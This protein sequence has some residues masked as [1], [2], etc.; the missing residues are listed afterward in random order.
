MST[1]PTETTLAENPP[2]TPL[3]N[4]PPVRGKTDL[5]QWLLFGLLTA[6]I[7]LGSYLGFTTS[8]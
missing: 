5:V 6:L 8:R 7:L 4:Q 2:P 1:E 3:A